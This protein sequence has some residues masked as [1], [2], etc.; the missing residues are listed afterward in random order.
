MYTICSKFVFLIRWFS[1]TCWILSSFTLHLT[2]PIC[3]NHKELIIKREPNP[4][5]VNS[6]VILINMKHS[7][8]I[9]F[10]GLFLNL[11]CGIPAGILIIAKNNSSYLESIYENTTVYMVRSISIKLIFALIWCLRENTNIFLIRGKII[12]WLPKDQHCFCQWQ[13]RHYDLNKVR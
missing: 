5:Q 4:V 10:L 6:F 3:S 9:I 12:R 8:A 13:I 11:C 7:V 2:I 1:L